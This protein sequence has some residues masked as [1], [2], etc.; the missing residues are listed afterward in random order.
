MVFPFPPEEELDFDLSQLAK[1]TLAAEAGRPAAL[2]ALQRQPLKAEAGLPLEEEL[3]FD[4]RRLAK[5]TIA[6]EA[7]PSE[8]KPKFDHRP[9]A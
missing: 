5:A 9:A 6:A 8:Q 7:A 4:L 1:A 2:A 3:D